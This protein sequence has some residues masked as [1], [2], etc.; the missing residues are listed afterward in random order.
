MCNKL[1]SND[2]NLRRWPL[3]AVCPTCH[4]SRP[5]AE[6]SLWEMPRGARG[7]GSSSDGPPLTLPLSSFSG[8]GSPSH[9]TGPFFHPGTGAAIGDTVVSLSLSSLGAV[10]SSL[11]VLISQLPTLF[12]FIFSFLFTFQTK[13]LNWIPFVATL[14]FP[15]VPWVKEW[16]FI[17]LSY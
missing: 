10:G 8:S 15:I 17:E 3:C 5:P 7:A 13:S 9:R 16:K 4:I 11:Q 12:R 2:R 1:W 14:S 6:V